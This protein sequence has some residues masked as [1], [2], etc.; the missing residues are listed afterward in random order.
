VTHWPPADPADAT[1]VADRRDELVAAVRAHAGRIA[2][3]LARLRGVDD[4]RETFDDHVAALDGVLDDVSIDVPAPASTDAVVAERERIL[5]RVREVCDRIA[6]EL[7]RHGGD[8]G[9]FATRVDGTRWELRRDGDRASYL[10]EHVPQF[11]D[12]V[13]AYNERVA[14][15][16]G[17]LA[18]VD[19]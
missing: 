3:R 12:F 19:V 5:G 11:A 18:G 1:A 2:Y 15:A 7:H 8:Y 16:E 13:R 9:T 6:G 10:R 4:G 17:D 14:D